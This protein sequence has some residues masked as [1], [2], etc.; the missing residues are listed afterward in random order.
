MKLIV[1]IIVLQLFNSFSLS[2]QCKA[3]IDIVEDNGSVDR[4]INFKGS[5]ISADAYFGFNGGVLPSGWISTPYSNAFSCPEPYGP[6]IDGSSYFWG[7]NRD[8]V[9][10]YVQTSYLNVSSGGYINFE[11]R[12]GRGTGFGCD[13][14]DNHLEGVFLEYSLDGNS[15]TSI[16]NWDPVDNYGDS[17][18]GVNL[19][20]WNEYSVKI[21]TSAMSSKTKFRWIQQSSTADDMDNWGLDNISIGSL[22][23]INSYLW[24]FDDGSTSTLQNPTHTYTKPGKYNISL[25]ITTT[26]GCVSTS[27]KIHTVNSTPTINKVSNVSLAKNANTQTV[28]LSGITDG[29][30]RGQILMVKASSSNAALIT[31]T[32]VE[33]TSSNTTGKLKFIP[34]KEQVGKSIITVDVSYTN[35]KTLTK[36]MSFK[37]DVP[38][39]YPPNVITKNITVKLDK[40]GKVSVLPADV[41]NGTTDNSAIKL[42]KLD[43]TNFD[44]SNVGKNTVKLTVTDIYNNSASAN[45]VVTV[46]DDLKPIVVVKNIIAE[47]GVD[48]T[49]SITVSDIDNG[50]KDNCGIKDYSLSSAIFGCANIGDNTIALS[51][52]DVNGNTASANANVVVVD[53]IKPTVIAKSI[54]VELD[55]N[56]T[57]KI[58]A[59]DLD[60]GSTDNCTI[61]TYTLSKYNFNCSNMGLNTVQLTVTDVNGNSA[62]ED[63]FVVVEDKIAPNVIANNVK[64]QIN[65]NGIALL[66]ADDV[67]G[68]LTDNCGIA[69]YSIDKTNFD[70]SNIGDNIVRLLVTDVNGNTA[71]ADATVEVEDVT[72]P[73]VKVNK[74]EVVLDENGMAKITELDVDNGSTD[75]CKIFSYELN[76]KS[77]D[78]S[79]VGDNE[80]ILSVED[81]NGNIS[82]AKTIVTVKDDI[83][84]TVLTK[85][86]TIELDVDGK[87]TVSEL[88]IDNG[89]TDNC[90]IFSYTLSKTNF[91]CS[92]IRDNKVTLT[93]EDMSGN[94][95]S[96]EAIITVNDNIIP[97][98]VSL[99]T[100]KYSCSNYVEFTDLQASDNCR[101]VITNDSE[102]ADKRG[103]DASGDYPAG[104]TTVNYTITDLGGNTI[105]EKVDVTVGVDVSVDLGYDIETNAGYEVLLTADIK[106]KYSQ[107]EWKAVDNEN[108]KIRK[109]DAK[110]VYVKV[111]ED[112]EFTA[113]VTTNDGCVFTDDV[114]VGVYYTNSRIKEFTGNCKMPNTITPNGDGVNDKFEI[115]C[116]KEYESVVFRIYNSWGEEVFRSDDYQNDW[117]GNGHEGTFYYTLESSNF[118]SVTGYINVVTQ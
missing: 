65:K 54:A 67:N 58:T 92:D 39:V 18:D 44:C 3:V 42:Y 62:T 52:T 26:S 78:C 94:S 10:R 109:V 45:A 104:V 38:D 108:A 57:A 51:V 28:D 71:F 75:N 101:I 116:I 66:T 5:G 31:N 64:I 2:A 77:F 13:A 118:S 21:P 48:G 17:P 91:N 23:S 102:F 4:K 117:E 93:V 86:I 56:G 68:G 50:S 47:L 99:P 14:P 80:V 106:G 15:W 37:V 113:T 87:A 114:M 85:N 20:K 69:N 24:K 30:I 63:G 29:G 9:A 72:A 60:N 1:L 83:A 96:A 61:A 115:P 81:F 7:F 6:S 107:I 33:Y 76:I 35:I 105:T 112:T 84:P 36:K 74:L 73:I 55:E 46:V 34:K 88:D 27:T 59:L 11:M 98:L 40:A 43:V 25:K 82:S 22:N 19:Y 103:A 49:A 16:K 110:S 53:I 79:N 90:E 32:S 8:G 100:V 95:T 41:D 12:Y 111:A 70:C 97:V 89:S